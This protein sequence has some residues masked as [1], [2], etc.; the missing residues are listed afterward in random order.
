MPRFT[1]VR[2]TIR[3]VEKVCAFCGGKGTDPYNGISSFSACCVCNG[4][5]KVLVSASSISCAHCQGMGA[6][7]TLVCTACGGKG[8]V[9]RSASP[10]VP[11]PDCHG[12]GDDGSA[13]ALACLKCRGCG[14]VICEALRKRGVRY[15]DKSRASV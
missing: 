2:D 10:L 14:F 8:S 1:H 9:H 13:S 11:C 6:V 7:K 5:G 4:R 15:D 12:M 3:L